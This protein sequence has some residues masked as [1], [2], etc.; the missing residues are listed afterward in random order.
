MKDT[1]GDEQRD[2]SGRTNERVPESHRKMSK[3]EAREEVSRRRSR[4]QEKRRGKK[5]CLRNKAQ[6]QFSKAA[7]TA[8]MAVDESDVLLAVSADEESEWIFDS[9]IAYHLCRDTEVFSTH[10]ACEG[11]VRMRRTTRR[12][13]I[14]KE[15]VRFCMADGKSMKVTGVRHISLRCKIRSDEAL[16]LEEEHSEFSRKIGN[17]EERWSHDDLQSDVLCSAPRWGGAGHLSENVQAL[18][19]G[20]AVTSMGSEVARG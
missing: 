8:M 6:D 17:A 9:R 15:I 11:L 4:D 18:Q 10:V 16:K 1:E 2:Y 3:E 20:S 12:R 7:T 19:F 14:G 13:V 5:N